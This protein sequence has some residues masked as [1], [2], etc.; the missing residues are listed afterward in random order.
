ME[1]KV[2]KLF[3]IFCAVFF[4]CC[5]SFVFSQ[6]LCSNPGFETIST[7]PGP[8]NGRGQIVLASPW[9]SLNTSADLFNSCY[10]NSLATPCQYVN[11]NPS[12]AGSSNA[13]TGVSYG[14]ISAYTATTPYR[15]YL[16]A[17][18]TSALLPGKAYRVEC[19]IKRASHSQYAISQIGFCFSSGIL[20]QAGNY[21]IGVTPQVQ[22]NSLLTDTTNWVLIGGYYAPPVTL[23]HITIGNFKTDATTTKQNMGA[24]SGSGCPLN[25]ESYYFIDDIKVEEVIE[26]LD[27]TGDTVI[28]PGGTTTLTATSSVSYWWSLASAPSD[29]LSLSPSIVVAPATSTTYILHGQ[30]KVDSARVQV[31]Q[32]PVVNLGNDVSFCEGDTIR[33]TSNNPN[34]TY[35]WSTG[36]TTDTISITVGDT[37][38][39]RVNN[40]GCSRLDTVIVTMLENPP[41]NLGSDTVF[42]LSN[43]DSLVLDGGI[44]QSHVWLPLGDTTRYYSVTA[45]GNFKVT[46]VQSNGC[47]RTDSITAYQICPPKIFIPNGFTPNGDLK[48]DYFSPIFS[49]VLDASLVIYNRWGQ[50]IFEGEG[51]NTSWDGTYKGSKAKQGTYLYLATYSFLNETGT[52]VSESIKGWVTLLR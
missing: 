44:A 13:H 39:A 26:Q 41:L 35:Q 46:A 24:Y 21:N 38:W 33:L 48:N 32:P 25:N 40:G 11:I 14:G 16:T 20:A 36:E 10:N 8:P 7:C 52:K 6:N 22:N 51:L 47:A 5:H 34:S 2:S 37:I 50:I 18:L 42:C 29:T 27:I 3:F 49:D 31:I 23:D 4:L 9:L 19:W 12:F 30:F 15:S 45:P 28:C 1:Y 17:P 43:Y